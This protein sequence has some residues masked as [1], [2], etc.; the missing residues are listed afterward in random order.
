MATTNNSKLTTQPTVEEIAN[1]I[2]EIA[3]RMAG[4]KPAIDQHLE[5]VDLDV[6]NSLAILAGLSEYMSKELTMLGEQLTIPRQLDI[7]RPIAG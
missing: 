1:R 3:A 2:C 5:D 6:G 7:V 4:L